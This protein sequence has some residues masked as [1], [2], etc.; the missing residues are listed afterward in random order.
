MVSIAQSYPYTLYS[1][2]DNY[3]QPSEKDVCPDFNNI[4][5]P[6][7]HRLFSISECAR[8]NR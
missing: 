5:C 4:A 3:A 8:N 6:L 2:V 1:L 7:N